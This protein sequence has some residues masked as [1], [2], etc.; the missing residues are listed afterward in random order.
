SGIGRRT[1]PLRYAA[2][3]APRR[4]TARRPHDAHVRLPLHRVRAR[5]RDPAGVHRRLADDVP[6]VLREP[7]Q[8]LLR[9]GGRLQGIRLLPHGLAL[10]G[11]RFGARGVVERWGERVWVWVW[12]VVRVWFWRVV[13][14][15][16]W[17]IRL[18]GER[19]W[20]ERVW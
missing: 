1:R 10:G 17:R 16:L 4:T 14:V 12:R 15:W 2:R 5:L 8:A 9:R 6:R 7:P 11:E 13:R 20:G 3:L 18:W 19:V